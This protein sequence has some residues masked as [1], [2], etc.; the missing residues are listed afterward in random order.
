V[1][2]ELVQ[3]TLCNESS[4]MIVNL[5]DGLLRN[6]S[7]QSKELLE[8]AGPKYRQDCEM[9][10]RERF[11]KPFPEGSLV[12]ARVKGNLNCKSVCHSIAINFA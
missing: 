11:Q 4:D 5:N 2:I 8:K 7:L 3:G 1:T 12:E 6:E 9:I 10:A